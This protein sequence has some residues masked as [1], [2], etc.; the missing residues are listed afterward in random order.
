MLVLIEHM[1]DH[2]SRWVLEEYIES[3]R[4]LEGT[5]IRL[6]VTGV[7]NDYDYS[8]LSS[9]GINVSRMHAW[10]LCDDPKTIVLDLWASRDLSLHELLV[11]ECFVVGGHP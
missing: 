2:V 10:E 9:H 11:T 6:T 3:S 7:N 4:V 1:E 5:G 8:V